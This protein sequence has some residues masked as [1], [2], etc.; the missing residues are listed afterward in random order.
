MMKCQP[1]LDTE[2]PSD[3][4]HKGGEILLMQQKKNWK[5]FWLVAAGFIVSIALIQDEKIWFDQSL[6]LNQPK[7]CSLTLFSMT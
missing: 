5:L 4:W 7:I 6:F 2:W 3:K 1:I